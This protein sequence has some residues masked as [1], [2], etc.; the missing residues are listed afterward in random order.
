M[1]SNR[2]LI[3]TSTDKRH[4]RRDKQ[5]PFKRSDHVGH[6]LAADR[7]KNEDGREVRSGGQ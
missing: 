1:A 4:V 5:G 2:E 7:Q 6:S 3:E